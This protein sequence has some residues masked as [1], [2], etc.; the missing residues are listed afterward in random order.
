MATDERPCLEN[1]CFELVEGILSHVDDYKDMLNA[2]CSSRL[3]HSVFKA[4]SRKLL[5]QVVHNIVEPEA[6]QMALVAFYC[7][8]DRLPLYKSPENNSPLLQF[9][10]ELP[11]PTEELEIVEFFYFCKMVQSVAERLISKSQAYNADMLQQND[12]VSPLT[13][14][15]LQHKTE[16]PQLGN[17]SPALSLASL[18]AGSRGRFQ[19]RLYQYEFLIRAM[20]YNEHGHPEADY[21][22]SRWRA[23][24]LNK[25][26][27]VEIIQLSTIYA[28]LDNDYRAWEFDFH[29]SVVEEVAEADRISSSQGI[30]T[31]PIPIETFPLRY[32]FCQPGEPI[33]GVGFLGMLHSFGLKLYK[34]L[35]EATSAKRN[36]LIH[37]A[38]NMLDF[39]GP[40][41][42]RFLDHFLVYCFKRQWN[43]EVL[44]ELQLPN[45][46]L[47]KY[48]KML[49][50]FRS[51][52]G[53]SPPRDYL[54]KTGWWLWDDADLSRMHFEQ[55]PIFHEP[56]CK[57]RMK[58]IV[59]D[60][61]RHSPGLRSPQ[62]S[63]GAMIST[64]KYLLPRSV[65]EE[66]FAKYGFKGTG[67]R[68]LLQR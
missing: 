62:K 66:F 29:T 5:S 60:T 20:K 38:H 53:V 1:L 9:P 27:I 26:D 64:G 2:M 31:V 50:T 41:V 13:P 23:W 4:S 11:F 43:F 48:S 56:I 54:I 6:R 18:T 7:D 37:R 49:Q 44:A 35:G 12:T 25:L 61:I 34:E 47:E 52:P 40:H 45:T 15:D 58:R 3:V 19:A 65:W 33:G 21:N 24:F 39:T 22:P 59:F 55:H 10:F 32:L 28:W 42:D 68:D 36:E 17:S 14:K 46:Y 67:Y 8:K 63:A 16:R 51:W 30:S 57:E